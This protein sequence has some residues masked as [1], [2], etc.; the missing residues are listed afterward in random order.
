MLAFSCTVLV[1]WEGVFGYV[2]TCVKS[3]EM[4]R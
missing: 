3:Q 2:F 4:A 1:T